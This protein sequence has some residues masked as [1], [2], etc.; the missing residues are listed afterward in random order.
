MAKDQSQEF[1]SFEQYQAEA[2]V[3]P[4]QLPLKDRDPIIVQNPSAVQMMRFSDAYRQGDI[5]AALWALTGDSWNELEPLLSELG[6]KGMENMLIDL[7]LHFDLLPELE[8]QGPSGGTITE[9]DPRKIKALRKKGY[10]AA[11]EA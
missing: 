7:Q 4:W 1:K 9:S 6:F 8:M 10:K 3:E 11:G 5:A 2:A